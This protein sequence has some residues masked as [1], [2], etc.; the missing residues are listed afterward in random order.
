MVNLT[1]DEMILRMVYAG[2]SVCIPVGTP[3]ER[4]ASY[5]KEMYDRWPLSEYQMAEYGITTKTDATTL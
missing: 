5:I 3:M 2:K 4:R 1:T